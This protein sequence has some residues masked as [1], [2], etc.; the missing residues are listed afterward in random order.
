MRKSV[1][2]RIVLVLCFCGVFASVFAQAPQQGAGQQRERNYPAPVEGDYIT[3]DFR[4]GTGETLPELRMHY[5]TIGTARRDA[6]GKVTNAVLILHGT[7]GSG[8]Q[9]L[10]PNFA[11]E[12]FGSGQLLDATKYFLILPDNIGHGRSSK[13]S[14]GMRARFPRYDYDDMVRAQRTLLTDGLG[15]THLRLILGTSMGCMHSFVWGTTYPDFMDAMMPL[16]CQPVEIVGRNRVMRKMAMDAIRSDP[17]WA[18]GNYTEPPP[19][20]RT[21]IYMLLIMGS[22]PLQ[23]QKNYLTRDAADKYLEDYM[24][25]RMTTTDANDFLYA[26]DSSR[27]YNPA[28]LLEKIT[29]RVMFVNSADDMINPPELGIAEHEIK[30][31]KNGKFVLLPITDVTR[32]HGTHTLARVWQEYLRELLA[33]EK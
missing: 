24:R 17:A 12:L 14:D 4:F 32:G 26:F 33:P 1:F 27:N 20:L 25:Q 31:I 18:E 10:N 3:K 7:T 28:P 30:R 5:M 13:L 6:A 29:A 22:A 11:N 2:V 9:F 23:M 15:V 19:G 21:A 8:R 16:A